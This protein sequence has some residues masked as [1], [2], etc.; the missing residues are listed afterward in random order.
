MKSR[1][2]QMRAPLATL[3]LLGGI[4]A[5]PSAFA[6][7]PVNAP[8]PPPLKWKPCVENRTRDCATL[9]VPLSYADLS[10][11]TIDLAVVRIKAADPARRVGVLVWNNGG[12]GNGPG[13][14]LLDDNDT[15][16]TFRTFSAE[17]LARFDIVG[18][19]PRGVREGIS[20]KDGI[21]E[22]YW[23][24]NFLARSDAELNTRMNLERTVNRNCRDNN[25]PLVNH[26]D[27]ASVVRDMEQPPR[28]WLDDVQLSRPLV[29]HVPGV[30]LRSLIP[31]QAARPAARRRDRSQRDGSAGAGRRRHQPGYDV[32]RLQSMVRGQYVVPPARARHRHRRRR[33]HGACSCE[34][35]TCR[36]RRRS[37]VR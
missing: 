31:R 9:T 13:S 10:K 33:S 37:A 35:L 17:L 20:C 8:P 30:P 34:S 14:A 4:T 27:S 32:D 15:L 7:L 22:V 36:A 12:P 19:D 2:A 1:N 28:G 16:I 23:E 29:W 3:V 25:Q 21:Q 24:T 5:F 11:G 26:V 18:F 6:D